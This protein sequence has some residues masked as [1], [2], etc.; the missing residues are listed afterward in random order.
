M[1]GAA[2]GAEAVETGG[3]Y[4][5]YLTA[6]VYL[7]TFLFSVVAA[8]WIGR[9][10][11]GPQTEEKS[12]E[13]LQP[14]SEDEQGHETEETRKQRY[15]A[16]RLEEC[17]SP[18]YWMNLHHQQED[19]DDDNGGDLREDYPDDQKWYEGINRMSRSEVRFLKL[20]GTFGP[21]RRL[22]G[23]ELEAWKRQPGGPPSMRS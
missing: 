5:G 13:A 9:K 11:P 17:S 21:M 6:F 23:L 22:R 20:Q 16:A 1:L 4:V 12:V 19:S 15:M 18:E 3:F 7:A 14:E 2:E 8:F 10:W